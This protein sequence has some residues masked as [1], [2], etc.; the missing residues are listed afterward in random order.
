[1]LF[2]LDDVLRFENDSK[3]ISVLH[4]TEMDIR[5]FAKSNL[6]ISPKI[7]YV[8]SQKHRSHRGSKASLSESQVESNAV[9]ISICNLTTCFQHH[10]EL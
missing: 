4:F 3:I 10:N 7:N 1:V 2:L 9:G 8:K 5:E 6:E